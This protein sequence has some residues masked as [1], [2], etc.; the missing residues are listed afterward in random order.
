MPKLSSVTKYN[1]T[2]VQDIPPSPSD[3]LSV[4]EKLSFLQE[5]IGCVCPLSFSCYHG[6]T[7]NLISSTASN[8]KLLSKLLAVDVVFPFENFSDGKKISGSYAF[9][10]GDDC[11]HR[12]NIRNLHDIRLPLIRTNCIGMVWISD[13]Q[14]I[15]AQ[16]PL[17]HVM[18]P[19]FVDHFSIAKIEAQLDHLHLSLPLKR[20]FLDMIN[21]LPIV[22]VQTFLQYAV[23]FHYSITGERISMNELFSSVSDSFSKAENMPAAP[24]SHRSGDYMLEQQLLSCVR[25][26]N[27]SYQT[28]MGRLSAFSSPRNL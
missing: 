22:Q 9:F 10:S 17:I 28:S 21:E 12:L 6:T 4:P 1:T 3:C 16:E 15:S 27:L 13:V 7:F 23:M 14:W 20:H 11:M 5:F 8:S 24:E 25:E 2:S 19:A 26:G 18:G